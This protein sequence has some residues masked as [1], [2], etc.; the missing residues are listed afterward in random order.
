MEDDKKLQGCING[1][2][3]NKHQYSTLHCLYTQASFLARDQLDETYVDGKADLSQQGAEQFCQ[4]KWDSTLFKLFACFLVI[5]QYRFH[6]GQQFS[7]WE[8]GNGSIRTVSS[9]PTYL[10]CLLPHPFCNSYSEGEGAECVHFAK[11]IKWFCYRFLA[12]NY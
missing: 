10:D 1:R 6:L 9:N 11:S 5:E 12:E 3:F 2:V 8:G 4:F 7:K